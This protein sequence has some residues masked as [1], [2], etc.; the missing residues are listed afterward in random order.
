MTLCPSFRSVGKRLNDRF[1]VEPI[2]KLIG[3][4]AATKLAALTAGNEQD[5]VVPIGGIRDE[6][7]GRTMAWSGGPRAVS[8]ARLR[9]IGDAQE[10]FEQ[11]GTADGMLHLKRIEILP[12][13]ICDAVATGS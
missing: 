10:E 8:S 11:A 2:G 3:V 13:P 7:H 6:A 9:F 1:R 5:R 4:V 12:L